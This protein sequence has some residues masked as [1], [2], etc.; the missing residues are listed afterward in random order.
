MNEILVKDNIDFDKW[1]QETEAMTVVH[2][3]MSWQTELEDIINGGNVLTG[4][5]LPWSK[6]HEL[7]AFRGGEV[8]LWAGPNGSG[9]S[10]VTGFVQMG[11]RQQ[12]VKSCV[13]SFEMPP[14]QTLYRQLRQF[15]KTNKPSIA[16]NS[17]FLKWLTGELFLYDH[18]GSIQQDKLFAVIRYAAKVLK[19]KHF[20]IDNL[21]M[22]VPGEDDYNAQKE[23]MAGAVALAI[24][25]NIHIHIVHHVRKPRELANGKQVEQNKYDIKGSG[26]LT[27]LVP[28]II[29]VRRNKSKELEI[30][31]Y[32]MKGEQPPQDLLNRPDAYLSVEK[33]RN[34]TGWE[35]KISLWFDA[36]S[37]Q[38]RGFPQMKHFDFIRGQHAS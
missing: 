24:E 19:A 21:M 38:Y 11:M 26:A 10:L 1:M 8:T 31:D 30:A 17:Q 23:F 27:D 2:D 37:Q 4:D 32:K 34:G 36:V 5:L 16:D 6:T 35:G 18:V 13:G 29:M 33:Q 20:W 12:G 9:K 7:I 15:S 28:Q 3:A 14:V 22:C 25:L